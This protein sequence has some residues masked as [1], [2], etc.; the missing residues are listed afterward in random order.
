MMHFT[1]VSPFLTEA[2]VFDS[3]SR[4]ARLCEA[5][6]NYAFKSHTELE[7]VTCQI[8]ILLFNSAC[9]S[10][11]RPCFVDGILAPTTQQRMGYKKWL[12]IYAKDRIT[13]THRMAKLRDSY[14]VVC[15]VFIFSLLTF[16]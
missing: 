11:L 7:Y 15:S 6:W 2:E 10:L 9:R 1:G 5:V 8:L 13:L 16:L 4:T 12:H 3:P 14:E